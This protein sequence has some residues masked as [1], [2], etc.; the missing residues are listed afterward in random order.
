MN[1]ASNIGR[2]RIAAKE[3]STEVYN[4]RRKEIIQAAV[5]VFNRSGFAG[6]SLSAVA[7][8]LNIHRASL[9]YYISSKEDLFDGILREVLEGNAALAN[10]LR[11]SKAS[12]RR[13]LHELIVAFMTS[14]GKNY[15]L[16][17][18]YVREN[19]SHV[20]PKRSAWS[21]VARKL[22][23]EVENALIAIIEEGYADRTFR[24]A[25]PARIVAYGV[26][27]IIGWTS[28]WFRPDT[29]TLS[30]EEIGRIYADMILCGLE[31]PA[32]DQCRPPAGA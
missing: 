1:E 5:R 25:G 12:P 6:A 10:R 2:R 3:E 15:P 28:R 22:N 31:S 8:E 27:G 7:A 18:I 14:Y 17:Y 21:K 11:T 26:L 24:R 9:Y 23:R 29:S 4:K 19:L 30:A 20:N 32:R 13:K 16:L